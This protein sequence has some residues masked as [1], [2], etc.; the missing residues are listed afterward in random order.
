MSRRKN[1]CGWTGDGFCIHAGGRYGSRGASTTSSRGGRMFSWS[2]GG[3]GDGTTCTRL[4]GGT[5]GGVLTR[6]DGVRDTG[7]CGDGVR[8]WYDGETERDGGLKVCS[9]RTSSSGDWATSRGSGYRSSGVTERGAAAA[10][11]ARASREEVE[12]GEARRVRS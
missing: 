10:T 11:C 4:G 1:W 2:D 5:G 3:D 6:G 8:T 12:T 9:E 7:G